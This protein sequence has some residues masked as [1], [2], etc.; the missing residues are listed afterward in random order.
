VKSLSEAL[1]KALKE[2]ANAE[3]RRWENFPA[4]LG[5]C[6]QRAEPSLEGKQII[7]SLLHV[8]DVWETARDLREKVTAGRGR[9]PID[10]RFANARSVLRDCGLNDRKAAEALKILGLGGGAG[11]AE[12]FRKWRERESNSRRNKPQ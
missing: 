8:A 7:S 2:L 10:R 6:G 9:Q 11:G 4:K 5:A 1:F 12:A 3:D